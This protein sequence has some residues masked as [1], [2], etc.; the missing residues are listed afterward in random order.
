LGNEKDNPLIKFMTDKKVLPYTATADFPGRGHGLIAWNLM[1]LGHDVESIALIANDADGI[2]EAVGTLFTLGIGIDPLT[3]L[4]LPVSNTIAPATQPVKVTAA[5]I[6]WQ[7]QL[8]DRINSIAVDGNNVIAYSINGNQATINS[9]GK[10]AFKTVDTI[11]A[12]DKP[13]TAV[14]APLKAS[15]IP[16]ATVKMV[17]ALE[18]MTAIAYWGGTVQTFGTDNML[19]TQQTLPQDVNALAWYS[20][21]LITGLADGSVVALNSK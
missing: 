5:P 18:N 20:T 4:V 10:A 16:G 8:T 21:T 7:V 12:A 11:P 14:P 2:N 9:K 6:D 13:I 3:P 17:I 19:K 1:N 15:L